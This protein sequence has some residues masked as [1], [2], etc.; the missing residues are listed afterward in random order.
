M[1]N[2][3]AGL[4]Y[5]L[6]HASD[7]SK[8]LAKLKFYVIDRWTVLFTLLNWVSFSD[9]LSSISSSCNNFLDF[10]L[11]FFYI[12]TIAAIMSLL[13]WHLVSIKARLVSSSGF[14][15]GNLTSNIS[16]CGFSWTGHSWIRS[17]W[18]FLSQSR[19][20]SF[21]L[22]HSSFWVWSVPTCLR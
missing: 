20:L 10:F 19:Y 6:K 21:S 8:N 2:F 14:M 22:L 18:K 16:L 5:V 17:L 3:Q 1:I 9:L 12:F 13:Y 15:V 7:S 11:T 4:T